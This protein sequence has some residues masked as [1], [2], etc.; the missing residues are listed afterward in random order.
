MSNLGGA[1]LAL[2]LSGPRWGP[3]ERRPKLFETAGCRSLSFLPG[4]LDAHIGMLRAINQHFESRRSTRKALDPLRLIFV[5]P[6][7]RDPSQSKD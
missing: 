1:A 5:R 3:H 2:F 4:F 6:G 7:H